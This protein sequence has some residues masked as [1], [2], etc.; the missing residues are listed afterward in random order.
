MNNT[1][2]GSANYKD[3][4]NA[5][6]LSFLTN[7]TTEYTRMFYFG[8]VIINDDPNNLNRIKVRIPLIDDIFYKDVDKTTGNNS[9]PWCLP[10]STHFISTPDA[11]A[12][13]V[14][15]LSDP[16]TPFFGR[17]Y[18]DTITDLSTT[19]LFEKL[20]PE[21]KS[22]SN[23]LNAEKSLDINIPKPV[24]TKDPNVINNPKYKMGIRGKGKNKIELDQTNIN[25][26][27]NYNDKN[28]ESSINL[29]NNINVHAADVIEVTSKKGKNK[30]Y[31]P[32][33]DETLWTY[34]QAQTKMIQKIVTLLNTVPA[35]S[36]TGPCSA[37]PTATQLITELTS[38]KAAFQKLKTTGASEK[39]SIN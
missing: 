10:T 37:S 29:N 13:V 15:I 34:L 23:W 22:L 35:T 36:P 31:H 27:Q 12:I 26:V 17:I 6:L 38:M 14:V 11:N 33:F 25:I 7:N 24:N 5:K 21:D 1:K 2:I 3:N 19:D 20:T 39:I 8:Q 30:N 18:L 4:L 9:L 32:V 16:K 28:N